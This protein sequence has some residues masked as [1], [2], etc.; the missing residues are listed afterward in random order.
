MIVRLCFFCTIQTTQ[1]ELFEYSVINTGSFTVD[2]LMF[3]ERI[4]FYPHNIKMTL[5]E[6][7][8]MYRYMKI[9][10]DEKSLWLKQSYISKLKNE[11]HNRNDEFL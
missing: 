4:F 10:T 11:F 2:F 8:T 7:C 1:I 3:F 6:H 5:K 9:I